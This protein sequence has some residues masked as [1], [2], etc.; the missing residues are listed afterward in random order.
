MKELPK[1]G[2]IQKVYALRPGV[3]CTN[4]WFGRMGRRF[5]F[6]ERMIQ[7]ANNSSTRLFL[8][9]LKA[10]VKKTSL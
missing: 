4:F 10:R 7:S 5:M 3:A 6:I 8:V 9:F 2:K 1:K